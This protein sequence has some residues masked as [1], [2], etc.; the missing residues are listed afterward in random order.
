MFCGNNCRVFFYC[1]SPDLSNTLITEKPSS[2][3]DSGELIKS[4]SEMTPLQEFRD[5]CGLMITGEIRNVFASRKDFVCKAVKV[6]ISR[7]PDRKRFTDFGSPP[8]PT[9]A[10]FIAGG[11]F[12]IISL[13]GNAIS[14][15]LVR[16]AIISLSNLGNTR[17]LPRHSSIGSILAGLYP[18]RSPTRDAVC[19]SSDKYQARRFPGVYPE[20]SDTA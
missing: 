9:R 7:L 6:S 10:L 16:A 20:Y 15:N 2:I 4:G 11:E 1:E 18:P 8:I 17:P 19:R 12:L 3:S 13:F 5:L 14:K